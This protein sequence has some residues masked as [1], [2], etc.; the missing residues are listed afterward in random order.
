MAHMKRVLGAIVDRKVIQALDPLLSRSTVEFNQVANGEAC[1]ILA[2]TSPYDLVLAQLPLMDMSAPRLLTSLRAY[3]SPSQAARILL[4]A[5]PGHS[6]AVDALTYGDI[7]KVEL[8]ASTADFR[9]SVAK[10]LGVAMR[11]SA[12]VLVNLHVEY[13]DSRS[14]QVYETEN[15]SRTGMLVRTE[16]PL[17]IGTEFAFD[18][19]LSEPSSVLQGTGYVVRHTEPDHE[20]ICGMGVEFSGL[21]EAEADDLE[22][23]VKEHLVHAE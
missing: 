22:L 5:S 13:D 10:A 1:V 17:E 12:R 23:F 9:A 11:T 18:L 21:G 3:G 4:L 14:T 16:H 19:C 2:S 6:R 15:I 20:R 7:D 8:S